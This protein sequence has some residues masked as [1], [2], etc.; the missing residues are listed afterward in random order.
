MFDVYVD[1]ATGTLRDSVRELA[2]AMGARYGLPAAELESR[3][4]RGRFRV[5][6]GVDRATAEAYLRD[7]SAIGARVRIEP[8]GA[9]ASDRATHSS[10][11]PAEAALTRSRLPP[12]PRS[13][14]PLQPGP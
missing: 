6:A 10:A 4:T 5:K 3:L 8:A 7:L 13:S 1:G 9:P 14:V 2:S 12:P 11:P